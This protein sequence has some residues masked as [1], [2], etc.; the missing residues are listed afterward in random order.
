MDILFNYIIQAILGGASGYITNDYAINMLF[1]EYTPLK[2][3]GVIKK[4]RNEFI[5]NISTLVENDII[6]KDKLNEILTD[7][8]FRSKFESLTEDF[9]SNCLYD[10]VGTDTFSH[11]SGLD[12]SIDSTGDFIKNILDK[13]SSDITDFL[14]N[15]IKTEDFLT[16]A[17][18]NKISNSLYETAEDMLNNT[19]LINDII[20]SIYSEYNNTKLK[21]LL[22]G[23]EGKV[24]N[25]TESFINKFNQIIKTSFNDK[26]DDAIKDISSTLEFSNS[27]NSAKDM[28]YEKCFNEIIIIDDELKNKIV[29]LFIEYINSDKGQNIVYDLCESLFSY[30]K[31]CDKTL[32]DIVDTSFEINLKAYLMENLPN[33]TGSIVDWIN[34]NSKNIDK[35]IEDSIDEIIKESDGLKGKLLN[36]IKNSYLGNLSEKYNIIQKIINYVEKETEPDKLSNN[37]SIKVIEYL[38]NVSIG[39]ILTQAENNNILNST[40]ASKYLT[41]YLNNYFESIL[42]EFLEYTLNIK[43]KDV[44][45]SEIY[46]ESLIKDK[47]TTIIKDKIL[48]SK[49]I[50]KR[51]NGKLLDYVSTNLNKN[52][53]EIF[54]EE[55]FKAFI[56]NINTFAMKSLNNNSEQIKN[57]IAKVIKTNLSIENLKEND[58]IINISNEISKEVYNRFNNSAEG[59]KSKEL[60]LVIDKLNSIDN[61]YKNSSE[62]LR[63]LIINNLDTIL[64]GSVK[65]IVTENLNKLSDD[66]LIA[67][68]NDFIGRELR[69]IMYFGGILGTAAGLLLAALQ[70]VSHDP[71]TINIANMLTYSLVGFSTNAIAI[72]MLFKPYNEIKVLSK[73]P[74]LRNFSLGYIVKNKKVF[75]EN[76]SIVIDKNLLSKES[77]NELFEKYELSLK[78]S[79]INGIAS[80]DYFILHKLLSNNSESIVNGS[81]NFTKHLIDINIENMSNF[82]VNGIEN[83]KLSTLLSPSSI[84]YLSNLAVD[85]LP[86][87]NEKLKVYFVNKMNSSETLDNQIPVFFVDLVKSSSSNFIEKY[88]D[89]TSKNL[90]DINNVKNFMLKYNSQYENSIN[91]PLDEIFKNVEIKNFT[92]FISHKLT[93]LILSER[94][95]KKATNTIA[96][97]FNKSLGG[98]KTFEELFNGKIKE[99]INNNIPS[100]FDKISKAIKSNI[101]SSKGIVSIHVKSEIKMNLG[102]LEKGMYTIMGGDEVVDELINKIM[103]NKVPAFIDDKKYELMNILSYVIDEKFYKA[104]VDT[105]QKTVNK[106]QIDDM[107]NTYFSNTENVDMI[108]KKVNSTLVLIENKIEKANLNDILK[109]LSLQDINSIFNAY[110]KEINIIVSNLSKSMAVNKDNI[111]NEIIPLL[112][113]IVDE[114][115]KSSS[116]KDLCHEFSNDDINIIVNNLMNIVNKDEF[117]SKTSNKIINSYK[118]YII[119]KDNLSQIIDAGEF[120]KSTETFIKNILNSNETEEVVKN[121]YSSILQEAIDLNFNFINEETKSNIVNIFIESCIKS[122]RR[123]LDTILKAIEFDK[124]ARDEINAMEPKKIHEMFNSFAGKYFKK[125]MIYGFGGF[126]FGVNTYVGLTLTGLTV[127]GKNFNKKAKK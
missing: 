56:P 88:Y 113:D 37:I 62:M 109:L 47:I 126:I 54:T 12:L 6:N 87:A 125:L 30:I 59:L 122:I 20:L 79:L 26:I 65:G 71:G 111:K 82:T 100:L 106:I 83:Y 121:V 22:D 120:R 77:I 44:I 53:N 39:E 18:L 64:G 1:K 99:Y 80:N 5:D 119:G 78:N 76:M 27:L 61:L 86:V 51:L 14:F 32:F 38:N 35:I 94:S 92:Q 19:D 4:T 97:L 93:K 105:L 84:N 72:N 29:N 104:H 43:I 110:E 40:I 49:T 75:A 96:N 98:N 13:H 69:P 28:L 3:G 85:S 50:N 81:Y 7:V 25:L 123:N 68:A 108:E 31:T 57:S 8:A 15:N 52:I 124:I 107:I 66:E 63:T 91:K 2:I 101:I 23:T 60:S 9:F 70:N 45:P 21:D 36:T 116:F 10:I 117:L 90:S 67:L 41:E 55:K 115:M 16:A 42:D 95:R 46:S 114:F 112:N 73:I 11:I 118:K 17:Q 24:N 103:V 74:F 48:S 33:V 34:V 89:I 127:V 102:F 58:N